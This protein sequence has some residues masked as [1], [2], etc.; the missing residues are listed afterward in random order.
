MQGQDWCRRLKI[1]NI[2][3]KTAKQDFIASVDDDHVDQ[4]EQIA[5]LM[6]SRGF[7]ISQVLEITGVITG[8]VTVQISLDDLQIEGIASI[9]KQRAVRK[10]MPD[11]RLRKKAAAKKKV[12]KVR[13]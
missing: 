10:I 6:R 11:P 9:E 5:D 12:K 13:S 1:Y 2:M 8:S 7:E 3:K 4:I